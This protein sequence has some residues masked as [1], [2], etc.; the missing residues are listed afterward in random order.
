MIFRET[1]LEGAWIIEPERRQDERGFFARTWCR[2]EFAAHGLTPDFVQCNLS[3]N[4]KRGTVRGLHYQVAPHA[5]AKLVRCTRGAIFDV[6]VDLRAGSD[7]YLKWIAA[8]LTADN[9]KIMFAPEGFGH[10]FQTLEDETEVFYQ[11][12][13]SHHP[14]SAR[15][16]RWDDPRLAIPWPLSESCI[17]SDRDRS[18]PFLETA[19][20]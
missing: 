4:R 14:E 20:C 3:Y 1:A 19:L 16:V 6:V 15:G 2:D 5:E 11:M 17:I 9:R 13:Q 12:S 10:G 7:T 18:L 8:E